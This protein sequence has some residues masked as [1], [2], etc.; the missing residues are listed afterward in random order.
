MPRY[1]NEDLELALSDCLSGAHVLYAGEK[2]LHCHCCE[3]AARLLAQQRAEKD[4]RI[5][6]LDEAYKRMVS[7]NGELQLRLSGV[8]AEKDARIQQLSDDSWL[9]VREEENDR[10]TAQLAEKDAEIERLKARLAAHSPSVH[11]QRS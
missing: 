10:L 3:H 8:V 9:V 11:T 7:V 6:V 1:T 2:L 5:D 4:V